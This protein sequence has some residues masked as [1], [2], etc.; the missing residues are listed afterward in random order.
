[1]LKITG[2]KPRFRSIVY[3]SWA[4]EKGTCPPG[5]S[6]FEQ[7]VTRTVREALASSIVAHNAL[8]NRLADASVPFEDRPC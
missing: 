6:R 5:A 8:Y 4:G 3:P 1:M 7:Y 2:N